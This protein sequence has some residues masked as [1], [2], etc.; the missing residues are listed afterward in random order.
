MRLASLDRMLLRGLWRLRGQ[1]LATALV[2]GA[3]IAL[4]IMSAGALASIEATRAAYYDQYRLA[5]LF[6][7]AKRAPLSLVPRIAAL[8]SVRMVESRVSGAVLLDIPGFGE[9]V[10]G[11][12]HSLPRD[13][14]LSLNRIHLVR[15]RIPD[16]ANQSEVL[17]SDP[18]AR[19]HGLQGGDRIAAIIKGKRQWLR[20]VGTALSPEHVFTIPPGNLTTDDKRFGVLWLDRDMLEGAFDQEG[21]FNELLLLVDASAPI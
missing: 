13:R 8:P 1:S 20:I 10:N 9:P 4:Y 17:V 3:G 18:F 16:A 5:N 12:V 21:A 2:I 19:A 14:N 7:S 15:G 11:I 6:A